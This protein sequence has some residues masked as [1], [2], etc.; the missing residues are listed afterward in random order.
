MEKEIIKSRKDEQKLRKMAGSV[1]EFT[2]DMFDVNLMNVNNREFMCTVMNDF[3]DKF[4]LENEDVARWAFEVG[5]KVGAKKIVSKLLA[6][7]AAGKYISEM[8]EAEEEVFKLLKKAKSDLSN[9]DKVTLIAGVAVGSHAMERLAYLK[10]WGY[11]LNVK[12]SEGKTARDILKEEGNKSSG[13][14]KKGVS[15]NGNISRGINLIDATEKGDNKIETSKGNLICILIV[16]LVVGTIIVAF[17]MSKNQDK[18]DK[19]KETET[20]S[21]SEDNTDTY[22]D[23]IDRDT[24]RAVEYGDEVNIDYVG[25]VDGVE[26]EGGS[27]E[28]YGA[29]LEIGSHRYIDDFEDQLVG[30]YIGE[31]VDVYV[32]FPEDYGKEDLNGKEALFVVTINGIYK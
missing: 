1:S 19:S 30:H 3:C 21:Y 12:N 7:K 27:T 14:G 24:S 28:G 11:D 17:V 8:A 5:C 29:S 20:S 18:K 16:F 4:D 23:G 26:F 31:T 25:S 15:K 22:D 13:K 2:P 32:T 10:S 6:K 9:D